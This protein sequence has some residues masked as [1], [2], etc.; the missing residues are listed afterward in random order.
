MRKG[1]SVKWEERCIG[2]ELSSSQDAAVL[3]KVHA[4]SNHE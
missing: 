1:E 3:A 4:H 2:G